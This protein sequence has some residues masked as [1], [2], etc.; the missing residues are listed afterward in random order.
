[1]PFGGYKASGFGREMGQAGLDEFTNIKTVFA[2]LGK[3]EPYYT[4]K[5]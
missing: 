1:M 5:S 4:A 3:R 2:H